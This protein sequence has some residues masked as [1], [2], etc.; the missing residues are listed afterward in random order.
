MKTLYTALI[1]SASLIFFV[2]CGPSERKSA[3]PVQDTIPVKLISLQASGG[4][5]EI[6]ATGVF[7]TDDETILGFKNGG[8]ISRILVK[9]G[10]PVRKGQLLASV[11]SS[12]VDARAGQV[13]LSVEKARRDYE[14]ASKL[15]RD[16]VATLEQLQNAKTALDVALQDVKSVGFNQ[17]YSNIY[18]P[19]S[20]Y[21]L[22]KLANDGQVVGPGTPVLQV[23]GAS[24]ANWKL[25]VG[26]GDQ[27]WAQIK[28]GDQAKISTDAMP[29]DTL[30][31]VVSKKSEGLDSQSGTFTIFLELREKPAYKLASGIFGRSVIQSVQPSKEPY[32]RIPYSALLDADGQDG[33]VFVTF[34][35]KKAKKQPVKIA[36]M[37]KD[38]VLIS[39]GL[40]GAQ[41]L[42]VAGSA[43]L[44][45]GSPIQIRK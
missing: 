9:E 3:L 30:A 11:H 24:N 36:R 43:Y 21:V 29:N 33:Y 13:N 2:G 1:A 31:A 45:D 22:A 32:W 42:I 25:K 16:S 17:Q 8:V 41:G 20:G 37:E 4:V 14:R 23:N 6:E 12:E 44:Q 28:I 40:E 18:S 5:N 38:E 7:S 10:D 15:Y 35:G 34:D 26:V 27:Q 39:S 19:V